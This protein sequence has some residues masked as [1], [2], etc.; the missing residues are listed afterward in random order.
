MFKDFLF[1]IMTFL[2]RN[3]VIALSG[4]LTESGKPLFIQSLETHNYL[5]EIFKPFVF[6]I[7]GSGVPIFAYTIPGIP[8]LFAG[9]SEKIAWAF[10]GVLVDRSNVEQIEV[11][12]NK[13]YNHET[14]EWIE[15]DSEEYEIPGTNGKICKF[16]TS[17]Y[18]T[19]YTKNDR[20]G[21]VQEY[22]SRWH[23]KEKKVRNVF[24]DVL[25]VIRKGGVMLDYA[26]ME[27]PFNSLL[28]ANETGIFQYICP[29][30][31]P[32][33][34]LYPDMFSEP[35]EVPE[36][37]ISYPNKKY[38]AVSNTIL[39]TM[40]QQS[41][42]KGEALSPL[43]EQI[44]INIRRLNGK[45][46]QETLLL[47]LENAT[48]TQP[49]MKKQKNMMLQIYRKVKFFYLPEDSVR[50]ECDQL[51]N[52]LEKWDEDLRNEKLAPI[53]ILW[54]YFLREYTFNY[55]SASEYGKAIAKHKV[56]SDNYWVGQMALWQ[57]GT[58]YGEC[59][60]AEYDLIRAEVNGTG[61]NSSCYLNVIRAINTT[62]QILFEKYDGKLENINLKD[63]TEKEVLDLSEGVKKGSHLE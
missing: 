32:S 10:T 29:Q 41:Y 36:R 44:A 12:K 31:Y 47:F 16:M 39:T 20:E 17:P 24:T 33:Y 18:G 2:R 43:E 49:Q 19:L 5:P 8:L 54:D 53:Y 1:P 56:V 62:R 59:D 28:L 51:I 63:F 15:L 30:L 61:H 4:N 45:L 7:E 9:S 27:F 38:V 6:S 21:K 13:F 50:K 60:S 11:V 26:T 52:L 23:E 57:K 34:F 40:K 3:T 58:S 46:N 48:S 35:E 37:W 55:I 14:E 22:I 42:S 25:D